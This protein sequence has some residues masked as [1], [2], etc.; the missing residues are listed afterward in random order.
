MELV[1][2]L[3][4]SSS[5]SEIQA[6]IERGLRRLAK[7]DALEVRIQ[8]SKERPGFWDLYL[9]IRSGAAIWTLPV[10]IELA[11]PIRKQ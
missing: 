11:L 6:G 4:G 3:I 9:R 5:P 7:V 1:D 2:S 8:E 10:D